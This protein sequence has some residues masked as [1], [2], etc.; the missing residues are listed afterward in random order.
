MKTNKDKELLIEQLKKTPIIQIACEKVN[1]SRATF[2]RLKKRDKKFAEAVDEAIEQGSSL[3]N[4]LAE[5]QLL[6]AI[7]AGN[8]S[9]VTYWLGRRHPGFAAKVKFDGHI[10]HE[11][12]ELTPEQ[13]ELVKRSLLQGHLLDE[14][15]S[16]EADIEAS[17]D[18]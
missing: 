4:D 11:S 2:Y 3:I 15:A 16:D 18:N 12:E 10:K 17:T 13:Q 5:T 14:G 1:V 9:A 7:R 6:N 8:L